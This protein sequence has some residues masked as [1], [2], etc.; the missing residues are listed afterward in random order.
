M[1][2]KI[3]YYKFPETQ[4]KRKFF[5][6]NMKIILITASFEDEQRSTEI[7][8]NSHYPIGLGYLHSFIESKGHDVKTLFLNDYEP[9]ECINISIRSIEDINP[10]VVGFQILT[11]NRVCS[12]RLIEIIHNKYSNIKI[13]IGG[14]HVSVMYEQILNKYP[15]LTAVLGEGEITFSELINGG[16]NIEDIDGIAFNHNGRIVKT[17]DRAL[18]ENLDELPFPKHEIFFNEFRRC[19]CLLTSRGCPFSCTFC[20]ICTISKRKIRYRSVNNVVDEI[21]YMTKKFHGMSSVW[22]HDDSLFLNND[23]V[24]ELCNEIVNRGIKIEFICSGRMKPLNKQMVTALEKAGFTHVLF[25][26]ESGAKEILKTSKKAIT[27]EDAINAIELFSKSSIRV[28]IFLI[29]GL[30]GETIETVKETIALVQTLQRIKYIWFGDV[31]GKLFIYPGAEVYE[32]AKA[33]GFIDDSYWLTD[34]NIPF[35]AAEH[36]IEKLL[37]FEDMMINHLSMYRI[38]TSAGFDAQKKMIY[39]IFK[40]KFFRRKFINQFFNIVL[41]RNR[42]NQIKKSLGLDRKTRKARAAFIKNLIGLNSTPQ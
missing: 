8:D 35:Y 32:I 5:S 11:G 34:K 37:E 30:P 26:L 10:D 21:E 2:G 7:Q 15:F 42:I 17:K 12:F 4:T 1:T 41:P 9:Q 18:I 16:K 6:K 20:C 13:V 24:I 14:I 33:K 39:L 36:S 31:M 23:R 19:G 29:I 3:A 28:T 38:F 40:D 25:G 22:I 27:K